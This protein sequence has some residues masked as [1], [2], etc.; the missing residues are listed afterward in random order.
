MELTLT[1]QDLL[2]IAPLLG[3]MLILFLLSSKEI[4]RSLEQSRRVQ[5]LLEKDRELLKIELDRSQEE[6]RESRRARLEELRKAAEFGRLSQ[7]LFHD[8]ITPLTSV[9]LH[10]EKL[11][12]G[13]SLSDHIKK[14]LEASHRMAEYVKDIRKT[15]SREDED[16][17]CILKE[18]FETVRHLHEYR[19][20]HEGVELDVQIDSASSWSGNPQK[21]RQIFSNLLGNALDS[22]ET[23]S[24]REKKIAVKITTEGSYTTVVVRDNGCGISDEN[25]PRIFDPFFTTKPVEKGTGIGLATVKEVVEKDLH[26]AITV[27]SSVGKGSTFTV[28]FP[29]DNTGL[30]ASH[31]PRH[32]RLHHE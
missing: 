6:L 8:L 7:G 13:S 10:T 30:A 4:R 22:F 16:R 5:E 3:L 27:E 24:G 25:L 20:R 28:T 23:V 31:P 12:D 1:A 21:L 32:T 15:L 19:L 2:T 26:G 17:Q 29:R 14:A 18:E 11:K 9:I